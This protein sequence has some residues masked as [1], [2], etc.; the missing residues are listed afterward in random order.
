MQESAVFN[1]LLDPDAMQAKD[2]PIF[3]KEHPGSPPIPIRDNPSYSMPSVNDLA[4]SRASSENHSIDV[5]SLA[6]G[7]STNTHKRLPRKLTKTRGNSDSNAER[8]SA[9]GERAPS[10][11][12][13][14]LLTKK[15][16]HRQSSTSLADDA[17]NMENTP[18]GTSRDDTKR[19]SLASQSSSFK[20]RIFPH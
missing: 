8:P 4:L 11:K 18:Y 1:Q 12:T 6:D 3:T 13:R 5:G 20:D 15:G 17:Q 14:G 19:N 10:E 9:T 16:P 2:S 7:S